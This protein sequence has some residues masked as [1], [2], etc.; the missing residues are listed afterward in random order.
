MPILGFNK[1]EQVTG[2]KS[3]GNGFLPLAELSVDADIIDSI[4]VVKMV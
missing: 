4:A 2:L 1:A 3:K